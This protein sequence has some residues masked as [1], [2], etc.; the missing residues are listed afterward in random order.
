MRCLLMAL[1]MSICCVA[2]APSGSPQQRNLA[3]CLKGLLDCDLASLT[4]SELSQ[5]AETSKKRNLDK[6]ME[7]SP[8]CDPSRLTPQ[9]AASVARA[10][11]QRHLEKCKAGSS[12]CDPMLL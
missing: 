4:A 11:K 6:C 1:A 3:S 12:T 5:V 2:Q 9:E 7:G 8:G 10:E